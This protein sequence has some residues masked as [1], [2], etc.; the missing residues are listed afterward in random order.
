MS[1]ANPLVA[2]NSSSTITAAERA[3]V[4]ISR[5]DVRRGRRALSTEP[6]PTANQQHQ[7]H[8]QQQQQPPQPPQRWFIPQ[9]PQQQT[10]TTDMMLSFM[11]QQ[12]TMFQQMVAAMNTDRNNDPE[13]NKPEEILKRCDVHVKSILV[14]WTKEFQKDVKAWATQRQLNEKYQK[15]ERENKYHNTFK[16]EMELKWQFPKKYKEA[17][18]GISGDSANMEYDIDKEWAALR[19][20]HAKECQEW[21]FKHQVKCTE[22]YQGLLDVGVQ[23]ANLLE[24]LE[25]WYQDNSTYISA[26]VYETTRNRARRYVELVVK[27]EVPVA[28]SRMKMEKENMQKRQEELLKAT[29]EYQQMDTKHV[30]AL[31]ASELTSLRGA[32]VRNS[33]VSDK[34]VLGHILK[35][36][37]DLAQKIGIKIIPGKSPLLQ[38]RTSQRNREPRKRRTEKP[39][40]ISNQSRRSSSRASSRSTRRSSSRSSAQPSSSSRARPST[41]RGDRPSSRT[42]S[43]SSQG[44]GRQVRFAKP[45]RRHNTNQRTPTPRHSRNN[46]N[47]HSNNQKGPPKRNSSRF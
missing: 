39:R 41:R 7:Q 8:L 16:S 37:P 44:S 12:S 14:S 19:E 21:I 15:L 42:S 28:T 22:F 33:A 29:E 31:V 27:E 3:D 5:E 35:D 40:N 2:D 13:F 26:S 20:A 47:K 45:Q 18:S 36:K 6:Y 34:D 9:Q 43:R 23:T 4:F 32:K 38:P 1:L 24:K 30:I 11:Q 17:D 46:L 25:P 10:V